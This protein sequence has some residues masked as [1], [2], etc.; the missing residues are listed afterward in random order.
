[1]PRRYRVVVDGQELGLVDEAQRQF[2]RIDQST[3]WHPVSVNSNQED[4]L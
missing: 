2:L 3:A 4:D 1:M